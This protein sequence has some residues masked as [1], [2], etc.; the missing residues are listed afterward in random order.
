MV[1]VYWKYT[2]FADY[3]QQSYESGTSQPSYHLLQRRET[4]K[5]PL[6]Q[7]ATSSD[8][9][10]LEEAIVVGHIAR[11]QRQTKAQGHCERSI[12]DGVVLPPIAIE[13]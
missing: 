5:V 7:A 3:K 9:Y 4:V 8:K 13:G 12:D 2:G 1:Q 6:Q 11:P 10:G